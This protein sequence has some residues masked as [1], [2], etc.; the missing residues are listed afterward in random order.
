MFPVPVTINGYEKEIN[1]PK[2]C[3]RNPANQSAFCQTHC[4]AV[5]M[6]G[7]PTDLKLFLQYCRNKDK[8]MKLLF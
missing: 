1:Y 3:P 7:V 8:G 6:K 2:V 5:K 4:N